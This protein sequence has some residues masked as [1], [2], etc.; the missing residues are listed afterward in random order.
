[1][2]CCSRRYIKSKNG[3]VCVEDEIVTGVEGACLAENNG[4]SYPCH[5]IT[6]LG[7][8]LTTHD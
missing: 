4:V 6:S 2:A 3:I 8:S 7:L 1:M 5:R